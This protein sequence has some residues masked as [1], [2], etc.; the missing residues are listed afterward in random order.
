MLSTNGAQFAFARMN[1]LLFLVLSTPFIS[2]LSRDGNEITGSLVSQISP[3]LSGPPLALEVKFF[4]HEFITIFRYSHCD[5]VLSADIHILQPIE[6]GLTRYEEDTGTVFLA[7]D[8]MKKLRAL[9]EG[10]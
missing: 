9:T 4:K 6:A 3:T 2:T 8:V 5:T 1:N 7:Q 10:V